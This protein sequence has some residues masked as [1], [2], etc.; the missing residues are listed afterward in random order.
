MANSNR[1][2]GRSFHPHRHSLFSS[3]PFKK[4]TEPRNTHTLLGIQFSILH[5]SHTNHY[6]STS[7]PPSHQTFSAFEPSNQRRRSRP[8]TQ[9]VSVYTLVLSI[10]TDLAVP[11]AMSKWRNRIRVAALPV[12]DWWPAL[13]TPDPPLTNSGL[14][15]CA[16]RSTMEMEKIDALDVC[17][18]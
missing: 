14:L 7:F 11:T 9:F 13:L 10:G 6:A 8:C 5:A 1:S 12:P 2:P 17:G 4:D 3:S 18:S 16:V 15:L